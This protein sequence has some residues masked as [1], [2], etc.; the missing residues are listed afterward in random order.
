MDAT[1]ATDDIRDDET[2]IER[3]AAIVLELNAELTQ[4][5]QSIEELE[6]Q[7]KEA[8]IA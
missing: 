4:A 1:S 2:A 8:A 7:R 6:I 3:S 5:K